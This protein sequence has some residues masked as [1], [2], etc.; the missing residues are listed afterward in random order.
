MKIS[1]KETLF[2]YNVY[3]TVK[4]F[5]PEAEIEQRVDTGQEPLVKLDLDGGS[6][7]CIMPADVR[8]CAGTVEFVDARGDLRPGGT[9]G[10]RE[11]GDTRGDARPG[12]IARKEEAVCKKEAMQ[13]QK[14]EVTRLVYRFLSQMTGKELAW[15]VLTGVRPTKLATQLVARE[16]SEER[17]VDVLRQDY[18]V[19][20]SKARLAVEIA[21]REKALLAP[22]DV[23]HGFSLYVGIPFCPSICSYCSFGSSP[24]DLWK[25]QV[26]AYLDVLCKELS[27]VA[28]QMRGQRLN[29]V[30]VG[31]GTPT[32]LEPGQLERLLRQVDESFSFHMGA[33]GLLEY[34]VEAGRPDSITREKLEVLRSHPVSRISINPQTMQQKTLDLV[35]RRHTVQDVRD[36]FHMARKLGFDN[37]NMDLIVGLP[38]ERIEDVR[39][40]LRQVEELGPDSLT[41]HSLAIKRAARMGQDGRVPDAGLQDEIEAMVE[42]GAVSASRMGLLPY[43]LYR[44]KDIA[45][46]FENVG[47]AKVDKAGIYN[48]LIME[49]VQTIVACGAG[50]ISKRIYPD[51]NIRRCENVKN[52]S[53]YMER[54]DEMIGRKWELFRE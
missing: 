8:E 23:R 25:G 15:G 26:D 4:A 30:Y 35:G 6:C 49:E 53:Q 32:T 17:A 38:G 5:F 44:Q 33:G 39:D 50:S 22:L 13:A 41:V 3:H 24:L 16:G 40:T 34:T 47:Y 2:T 31:G 29:T 19:A 7:F 42:A 21:G 18:A 20:P 48:I 12:G 51:G 43:Y 46:N 9:A 37:I 14:R 54:I 1:C 10:M 52:V 27:V 36:G 28:A 11:F 45:G